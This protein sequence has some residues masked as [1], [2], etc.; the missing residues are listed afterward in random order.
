MRIER[1]KREADGEKEDVRRFVLARVSAVT[2]RE[3]PG[4][5][6]RETGKTGAT[7]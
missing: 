2:G 7:R 6:N 4:A 1:Q 3:G 5:N